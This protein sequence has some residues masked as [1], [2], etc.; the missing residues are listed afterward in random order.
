MD[1]QQYQ[2]FWEPSQ[3][4]WAR[5]SEDLP[6]LEEQKEGSNFLNHWICASNEY[7]GHVRAIPLAL[8]NSPS[9]AVTPA[10]AKFTPNRRSWLPVPARYGGTS[11]IPMASA[12]STITICQFQPRLITLWIEIGGEKGE[13]WRGGHTNEVNDYS[14]IWEPASGAAEVSI[15]VWRMGNWAC[16]LAQGDDVVPG[17]GDWI[18]EADDGVVAA[19]GRLG[20]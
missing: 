14:P 2:N 9:R 6:D 16:P 20:F 3:Q 11:G 13:A 5:R 18:P 1:A 17:V 15:A 8:K 4:K 10:T 19:G 12:G 7:W